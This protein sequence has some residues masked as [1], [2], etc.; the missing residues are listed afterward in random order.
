MLSIANFKNLMSSYI[1]KQDGYNLLQMCIAILIIGIL[2]APLAALYTNYQ[3]T[4]KETLTYENVSNAVAAMQNYRTVLGKYPCP[5]SMTAL[6]ASSTSTYGVPTNCT[7]GTIGAAAP[8]TCTDGV[9]IEQSIRNVPAP[10]A[11]PRVIVGAI[12]FRLLQLDEER[13]LDGYGNRL[14]YAITASQTEISTFNEHS[15]AIAVHDDH[16]ASLTDPEG[17]AIFVV[18]SAG[19]NGIGAYNT[20]GILV[21]PCAGGHEAE[22]C[23]V[24]FDIGTF[25]PPDS[26]YVSTFQNSTNGTNAFDDVVLYF[27]EQNDPLWKRMESNPDDINDLSP[28]FI[29]IGT[30]TPT[31]ELDLVYSSAEDILRINGTSGTGGAIMTNQICDESGNNCFNTSLL[32]ATGST[33]CPTGEYVVRIENGDVVCKPIEVRCTAALPVFKGL[34][35][36]GNPICGSIPGISCAAQ[37]VNRCGTGDISLPATPDTGVTAYFVSSKANSCMAS[38][39]RCN[40]GTFVL[41][42]SKSGSTCNLIPSSTSSGNTCGIGHGGRTYT[43]NTTRTCNTSNSTVVSST[44]TN[45]IPTDC[46]CVGTTVTTNPLCSTLYSGS[47]GTITQ[48]VTFAPRPGFP[49]ICDQST[50][51]NT[52]GCSCAGPGGP[53]PRWVNTGSCSSPFMVDSSGYPPQKEQAYNTTLGSCG[54]NDTGATRGGCVCALTTTTEPRDHVCADPVCESPKIQD[55][56]QVTHDPVSCVSTGETLLTAGSC[57]NKGFQWQAEASIGMGSKDVDIGQ[58]CT[59]SDHKANAVRLCSSASSPTSIYRCRCQPS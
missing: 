12:P 50:A 25:S 28:N 47:S 13:T 58:S 37:T 44:S 1:R 23:N 11:N 9:C 30:A 35:A 3:K 49:Y 51:K 17:A 29:G 42:D 59:C 53:S 39:Y 27:T 33:S 38:R 34:D 7:T 16:G 45:T 10:L 18:Y 26:I 22:N 40:N 5:S 55:I 32:G 20:E 15:G 57:Q 41:L 24:G 46:L 6:K 4:K 48:T 52:S 36:S 56:F 31:V 21:S 43:I 54:W 14:F 8:G 19:H 2:T